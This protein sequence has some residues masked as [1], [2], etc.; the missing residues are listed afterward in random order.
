M[1]LS[2]SERRTSLEAF[3][4]VSAVRVLLS[5]VPNAWTPKAMW[6]YLADNRIHGTTVADSTLAEA[7]AKRVREVRDAVY[8]ASLRVPKATCLVQAISGWIM[9]Q[10]SGIRVVVRIGVQKD[11]LGFSAHAWLNLGDET[12]IGGEGSGSRFSTLEPFQATDRLG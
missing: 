10:R 7:K 8:R 6:R 2:P 11:S 9:L 1:H 5:L 3:V 4:V 12:I